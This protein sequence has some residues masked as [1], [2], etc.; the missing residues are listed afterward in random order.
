[1]GTSRRASCA[2]PL[3]T[4]RL[5]SRRARTA[6][7]DYFGLPP[8]PSRFSGM[9]TVTGSGSTW[10]GAGSGVGDGLSAI[11]SD[12]RQRQRPEQGLRAEEQHGALESDLE[13]VDDVLVLDVAVSGAVGDAQLRLGHVRG[14]R[15][16]LLVGAARIK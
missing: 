7:A 11:C 1:M 13:A 15:I 10:S 3:H 14:Q 4:P 8:L 12:Y 9:N 6:E 5:S 16:E 2:T